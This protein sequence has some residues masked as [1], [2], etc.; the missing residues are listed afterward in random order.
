MGRLVVYRARPRAALPAGAGRLRHRRRRAGRRDRHLGGGDRVGRRAVP[1]RPPCTR[2]RRSRRSS[3]AAASPSTCPPR[4][5]VTEAPPPE[6]LRLLRE[7]IDPHGLLPARDPRRPG[8]GAPAARG[9]VVMLGGARARSARSS[10]L[11]RRRHPDRA[12]VRFEE[13]GRH[14]RAALDE[15]ASRVANGLAGARP[16]QGR[17]RRGD[18]A[19]PARVPRRLVRHGRAGHRRGAA[20][21]R[22]ARRHARVHAQ[23]GRAARRS[24]STSSGSTASSASRRS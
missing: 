6:A 8:R 20:Q 17:P 19:E 9:A 18:A 1:A 13:C 7:E 10:P 24:S 16:R 14:V 5:P 3:P 4:V 12:I 15:T 21:H 23:P 11:G 2:A 22:P